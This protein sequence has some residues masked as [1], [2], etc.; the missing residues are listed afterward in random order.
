MKLLVVQK[1]NISL[2]QDIYYDDEEDYQN[3]FRLLR[4]ERNS[5]TGE[6]WL[7]VVAVSLWD[8]AKRGPS[9][10]NQAS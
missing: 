5:R 3:L 10:S 4:T 9:K 8:R 2:V 6:C 7:E 1:K